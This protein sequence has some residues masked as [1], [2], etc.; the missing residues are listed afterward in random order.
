MARSIARH[1]R[2]RKKMLG[3]VN[4]LIPLPNSCDTRPW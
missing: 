4:V 3:L 2:S 1:A